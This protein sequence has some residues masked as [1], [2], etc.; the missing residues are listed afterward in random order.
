MPSILLLTPGS[1]P[2]PINARTATECRIGPRDRRDRDFCS[3]KPRRNYEGGG[4]GRGVSVLVSVAFGKVVGLP[5]G[6]WRPEIV[7]RT[8][9]VQHIAEKKLE[10]VRGVG[11]VVRGLRQAVGPHHG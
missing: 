1:L 11:R 8:E 4:G 3:A 7:V 9:N 5:G 10:A 2:S 6:V